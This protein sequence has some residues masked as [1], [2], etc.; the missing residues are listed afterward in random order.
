MTPVLQALIVAEHVYT[1]VSGK[2]IIAGT[3]NSIHFSRNTDLIEER[4][5]EEGQA[6]H[7]VRDGTVAGSPYAYISITDV[8]NGTELTLQFVSLS[9]NAVIF[10]TKL[11]IECD[12]RLQTIEIV[13]PLP[14]LIVSEAGIYAFE[15]VCEG[16]IIGSHRIVAL[17]INEN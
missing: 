13:A 1:D 7:F 14:P 12:D 11:L 2:K 16:V 15:I 8:T 6:Q 10:E 17:E 9:K 5:T 3:F 4:E